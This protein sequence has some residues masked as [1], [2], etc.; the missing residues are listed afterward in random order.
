MRYNLYLPLHIKG[1]DNEG[2]KVQEE[3]VSVNVGSDGLY[4]LTKHEWRKNEN[5]LLAIL[6]DNNSAAGRGRPVVSCCATIMSFEQ[7]TSDG[8]NG[9]ALRFKEGFRLSIRQET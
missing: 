6:M 3:T 8:L 5:I 4:A 2:R 9:V 7:N 1:R